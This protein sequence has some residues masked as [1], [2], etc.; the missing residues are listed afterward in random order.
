MIKMSIFYC[1]ASLEGH[2]ELV[3]PVLIIPCLFSFLAIWDLFRCFMSLSLRLHGW[4][5]PLCRLFA[6]RDQISVPTPVQTARFLSSSPRFIYSWSPSSFFPL[7][8]HS[9]L[10]CFWQHCAR[11][12]SSVLLFCILFIFFFFSVSPSPPSMP[13]LSLWFVESQELTPTG[14]AVSPGFTAVIGISRSFIFK[15]ITLSSFL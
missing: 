6:T 7:F 13:Y 10:V 3:C 14:G 2:F 11:I 15:V 1:F 8:V 12:L 9:P 5:L 4:L